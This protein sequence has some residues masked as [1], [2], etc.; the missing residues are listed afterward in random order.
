MGKYL[1]GSSKTGKKI[2]DN[3]ELFFY[4]L[5]NQEN[6]GDSVIYQF[7]WDFDGQ[8]G[9]IFIEVKDGKISNSSLINTSKNT[10]HCFDRPLGLYNDPSLEI[11]FTIM[12][13]DVGIEVSGVYTEL[14]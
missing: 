10:C 6:K 1:S 14:L 13:A 11:V 4:N 9:Y 12:L 8:N 5:T 7:D 2:I 3:L